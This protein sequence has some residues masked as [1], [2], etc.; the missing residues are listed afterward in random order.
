MDWTEINVLFP[1]KEKIQLFA[2]ILLLLIEENHCD[3]ND[4]VKQIGM[5][6]NKTLEYIS[7]SAFYVSISVVFG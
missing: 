4:V 2:L 3:A 6:N 1:F 7:G 5:S